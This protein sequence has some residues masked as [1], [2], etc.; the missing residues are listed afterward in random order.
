MTNVTTKTDHRPIEFEDDK[1]EPYTVNEKHRIREDKVY[2]LA[3]K[4]LLCLRNHP[5]PEDGLPYSTDPNKRFMAELSTKTS[6]A[7]GLTRKAI[8]FTTIIGGSGTSWKLDDNSL[9]HMLA[10]GDRFG[11]EGRKG[12]KGTYH[13]HALEPL[14]NYFIDTDGI[15]LSLDDFV[16]A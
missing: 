15:D 12:K 11:L 13:A 2:D 4:I 16:Y 7:D 1:N 8:R 3:L 6:R 9:Q 14:I 10:T 5:L